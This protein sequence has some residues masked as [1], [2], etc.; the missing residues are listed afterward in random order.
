MK[1]TISLRICGEELEPNQVSGD[2]KL[3]PD[4]QHRKGEL[5]EICSKKGKKIGVVNYKCGV[6]GKS[7]AIHE[8]SFQQSLMKI[9]GQLKQYKAIME[10]YSDLGCRIDLFCGIWYEEGEK[11]I[12]IE[13]GVVKMFSDIYI[14]I[15]LDEY[16]L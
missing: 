1:Y 4:T 6:W 7:I 14:K 9:Y 2:L 5:H 15:D 3:E 8:D 16:F 10:K 11:K 12:V 13:E